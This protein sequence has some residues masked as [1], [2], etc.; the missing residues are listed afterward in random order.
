MPRKGTLW[1]GP[2]RTT[3]EKRCALPRTGAYARPINQLAAVL[4]TARVRSDQGLGW[5]NGT[6]GVIKETVNLAGQHVA[7]VRIEQ[8]GNRWWAYLCIHG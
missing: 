4:Q 1:L 6:V 7:I 8:T 5:I 3:R 2:S